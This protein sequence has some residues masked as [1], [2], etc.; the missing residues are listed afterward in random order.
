VRRLHDRC[1]V[2]AKNSLDKNYLHL[3]EK[4]G[5]GIEPMTHVTGLKQRT[6]RG[7]GRSPKRTGAWFVKHRRS[8]A[9]AR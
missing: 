4:A 6:G 3:A 9:R 1:R 5:R 2:G 7:L 8:L